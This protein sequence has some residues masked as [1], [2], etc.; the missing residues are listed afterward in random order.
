[1]SR[2]SDSNRNRRAL[3]RVRAGF[4]IS[5][6]FRSD[7]LAGTGLICD[8]SLSGALIRLDDRADRPEVGTTLDLRFSMSRSSDSTS[9]TARGLVVRSSAKEF[10]VEWLTPDATVEDLLLACSLG[11]PAPKSR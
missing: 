8:I 7:R 10:A 3:P 1:M 2:E 5:V 9:I 11:T 6:D 4:A